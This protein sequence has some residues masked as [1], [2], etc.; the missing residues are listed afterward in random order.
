MQMKSIDEPRDLS[1]VEPSLF[2]MGEGCQGWSGRFVVMSS[3]HNDGLSSHRHGGVSGH[4]MFGKVLRL[5]EEVCV[6]GGQ[7]LT[8]DT[9]GRTTRSVQAGTEVGAVRSSS[10]AGNDRR[11]KG[12]HLIDACREGKGR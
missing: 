2:T 12:P 4:G 3:G 10:E 5:R 8:A 1:T 7:T 11:A 9:S 6:G